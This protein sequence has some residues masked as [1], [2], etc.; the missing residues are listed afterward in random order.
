MKT[1]F[2][3]KP[4]VSSSDTQHIKYRPDIDGLRAIAVLAVVAFHAFPEKIKGGFIGVDIFFVISGFLITSIIFQSLKENSFSFLDFYARRIRRIFPALILVLS[5]C[6]AIGWFTFL[7]DEYQQLGRHIAGGVLFISNFV[8]WNEIGYFDNAAE[9]K[10]LLHLWS[11]GI[12][13]Q[14]YL[15]WPLLAFLSWKRKFNLF[16]ITIVICIASFVLNV[17][18]ADKDRVMDFFSPQTRFWELFIGSILA[19]LAVHRPI[20]NQNFESTL[21][22]ALNVIIYRDQD[23]SRVNTLS[24]I[25]STIGVALIAAGLILINKQ[26][27]FPG[28]WAL[29]PVIGSMFLISAGTQGWFNKAVL[30]HPVLV[31]IGLISFPL[32]LWHW[33][34][35]SFGRI[36]FSEAPPPLVRGALII[37]SFVFAWLTYL[38]VEKPIRFGHHKKTKTFTLIAILIGIGYI[39]FNTDLRQGFPFRNAVALN[40]INNDLLQWDSYKSPGCSKELGVESNFCIKFG[41]TDN[42]KI[43]VIGDSTGNSLAPGL[44]SLLQ[45]KNIGLINLGGWTCPP[46]LGLIET[47]HWGKLN[48]CPDIIASTYRYLEKNKNIETVIF[49]VFAADIKYLDIPGVPFD[50]PVEQKFAVLKNLIN[51]SVQQII[52]MGKKVIVTYD[53]P[54]SNVAS[55]DCIPRPW[56]RKTPSACNIPINELPDREPN[57]SLF[58]DLFKDNKDVC[59]FNQSD[60]L[61]AR[62]K[63]NFVDENGHLLLRD[64]HHLS[65]WGSR[66]MAEK[67]INSGCLNF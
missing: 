59:I 39:G 24:H 42:I 36:I 27:V 63:L 32:Y 33:P 49:T 2:Q 65:Y 10:V 55:R 6:Y 28:W 19:Y 38:L 44:A 31:W 53:A 66:K 56:L 8:L 58:N 54:Y 40:K 64:T 30:S 17:Q 14:F 16:T 62:G 21:N 15:I 61:L 18:Y 13:E 26:T 9:T 29:L 5:F 20:F 45:E 41:N 51:A 1:S 12:E 60:L 35:L 57:I 11:L 46:I 48:K 34:L 52:R 22:S 67:M 37:I 7:Q 4:T 25:R 3:T 23:E 47:P 43:A 50:A